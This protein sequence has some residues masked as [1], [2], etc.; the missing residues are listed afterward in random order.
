MIFIALFGLLMMLL[1]LQMIKSPND[2]SKVIITFS[3]KPYFHVF[4]IMSRLLFAV[5]FIHYADATSAE[6]TN[7]L[8]GFLMGFTAIFLVIIGEK[9]HRVFARWSAKKFN[10]VFQIAGCF[11][12]MFGGYIIFTVAY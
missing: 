5:I 12:L 3:E 1:S 9:K 11:S 6:L 8:L 4:E 10:S 2:F 7:T